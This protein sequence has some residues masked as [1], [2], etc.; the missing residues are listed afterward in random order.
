M[1]MDEWTN[2]LDISIKRLNNDNLS[3]KFELLVLQYKLY[4]IERTIKFI[5]MNL[6]FNRNYRTG[7]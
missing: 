1:D 6:L 4:I 5:R 3:D 2:N 7:S